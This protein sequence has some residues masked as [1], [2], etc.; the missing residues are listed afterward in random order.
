[1][2]CRVWA[3]LCPGIGVTFVVVV[4]LGFGSVPTAASGKLNRPVMH[5][6]LMAIYGYEKAVFGKLGVAR[7]DYVALAERVGSQC[8]GVIVG[9]ERQAVGHPLRPVSRRQFDEIRTLREE[10]YAVL[11]DTWLG[12]D[13]QAAITLATKLRRLRWS[14]PSMRRRMKVYVDA[15]ERRFEQRTPK[16]CR[17]MKA[18][19][20]SGYRTLAPETRAFVREYSPPRR[21]MIKGNA[22]PKVRRV[23][24]IP[25]ELEAKRYDRPLVRQVCVLEGKVSS[26][27]DGLDVISQR[28]ERELGFP[29]ASASEG[30]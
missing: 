18:W 1:V 23:P 9:G 27:F 3:W 7:A 17:D 10:M 24:C 13:R 20:A 16:L 28:L 26:S 6:Y 2:L 29:S 12:P 15:L 11:R 21:L 30:K 5:E 22:T 19:A 14:M 8:G 4:L 25:F